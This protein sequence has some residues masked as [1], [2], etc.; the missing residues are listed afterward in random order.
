M[1]RR[2]AISVAV[3]LVFSVAVV[4]CAAAVELPGVTKK[5]YIASPSRA[6]L[7]R[8]VDY[9]DSGDYVAL[10][11]LYDGKKI[12]ILKA[13]VKVFVTYPKKSNR[14]IKIR[15]PGSIHEIW[16]VRKAVTLDPP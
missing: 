15:L 16:T 11:K 9:K 2:F 10:K 7:E 6:I 13:G 8:A 14:R 5:G 1:L 4:P 3:V 12:L